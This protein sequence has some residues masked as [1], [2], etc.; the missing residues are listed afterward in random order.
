M[1][2]LAERSRAEASRLSMSS[3]DPLTVR[4][5]PNAT[6]PETSSKPMKA[7]KRAAL[8]ADK[9]ASSL[10]NCT[11]VAALLENTLPA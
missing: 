1:G 6:L 2:S 7:N 5:T 3:L 8:R 4:A 9:A 10:A 11:A